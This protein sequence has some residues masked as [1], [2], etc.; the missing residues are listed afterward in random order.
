MADAFTITTTPSLDE[1]IGQ[2]AGAARSLRD[3]TTFW[4]QLGKSIAD[5]A[6]RAW[7]LRRRSGRLRRSL[8]WTGARL[9]RGGIY[10]ADPDALVIG[11]AVFY[12]AFSHFGTK[13]QSKRVLLSVDAT[14]TTK[15]L[16]VW[17]RARVTGAGLEVR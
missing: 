4:P 17:P 5:E 12:A 10:K 1:P 8:T 7:P 3:L 9:G 13:R 6:Q 2:L 16:E 11:S 15:R 14:D